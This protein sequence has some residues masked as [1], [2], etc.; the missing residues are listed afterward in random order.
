VTLSRRTFVYSNVPILLLLAISKATGMAL[1]DRLFPQ[2]DIVDSDMPARVSLEGV[3]IQKFTSEQLWSLAITE[4]CSA[5][6]KS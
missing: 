1:R 5:Q 2:S 6:C 4:A 3:P